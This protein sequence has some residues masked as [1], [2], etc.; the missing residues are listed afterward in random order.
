MV[1][2]GARCEGQ[3][4]GK[5]RRADRAGPPCRAAP[6]VMGPPWPWHPCVNIQVRHSPPHGS[7]VH[8]TAGHLE[9][10]WNDDPPLSSCVHAPFQV[11]VKPQ[12][13]AQDWTQGP[14]FKLKN[15]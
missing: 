15:S 13:W 12:E 14:R 6:H 10:L 3:R 4:Q 9:G 1:R 8:V 2:A 5:G 7:N 11:K